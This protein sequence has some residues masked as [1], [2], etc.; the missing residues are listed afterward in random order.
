M[1]SRSLGMFD[2]ALIV[3]VAYA[4]ALSGV[5]PELFGPPHTCGSDDHVCWLSWLIPLHKKCMFPGL[6]RSFIAS[7]CSTAHAA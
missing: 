7:A 2:V 1:F 6:V 4:A 3:F 5:G